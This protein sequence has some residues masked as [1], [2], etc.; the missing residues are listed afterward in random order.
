MWATL[1]RCGARIQMFH[2]V[3]GKYGFDAPTG[4]MREWDRLFFESL[5]EPDLSPPAGVGA[6]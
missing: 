2:G 4:S 1:P 6:L 5:R 3:A